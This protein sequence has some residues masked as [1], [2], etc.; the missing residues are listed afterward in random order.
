MDVLIEVHDEAE[1]DRA[2]K[3]RSP[4]IGINNRDLRSFQTDIATTERLVGMIPEGYVAVSESGINSYADC[5][6]L[7]EHGVRCFLVGESL[8]RQPDV[9]LATRRL[10]TGAEG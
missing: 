1:M 7:S 4:L 2:L 9:A 6:R 10:L 5:E 8:M 3:L